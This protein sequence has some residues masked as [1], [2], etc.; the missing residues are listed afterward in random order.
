V[1]ERVKRFGRLSGFKKSGSD[2]LLCTKEQFHR[3]IEKERYRS[4]RSDHPYALMI[5][6]LNGA[7]NSQ[8]F[9]RSIREIRERIRSVDELGWYDAGKLGILLPYT[10]RDGAQNLAKEICRILEPCLNGQECLAC[11]LFFYAPEE[12]DLPDSP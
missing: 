12:V 6:P 2:S 3:A 9:R 1:W 8:T 4:D 11:D 7:G 10:T 5:I